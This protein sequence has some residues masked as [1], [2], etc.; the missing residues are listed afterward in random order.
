MIDPS[1]QTP[2]DQTRTDLERIQKRLASF[3]A[4]SMD[5]RARV[6]LN[7]SE[8]QTASDTR[9]AVRAEFLRQH[10]KTEG[11]KETNPSSPKASF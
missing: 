7:N 9:E 1:D 6:D 10:V 3:T 11:E 5:F 2:F 4:R 8:A